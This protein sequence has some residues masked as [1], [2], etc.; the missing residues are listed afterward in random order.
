MRASLRPDRAELA[1]HN[2]FR[3]GNLTALREMALRITAERVTSRCKH[4]MQIKQ[5]R[6]RGIGWKG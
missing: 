2:F 4:Y 1:S 3:E 6:G 5:I